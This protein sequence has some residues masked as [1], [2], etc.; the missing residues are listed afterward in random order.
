[1]AADRAGVPLA[2]RIAR[3]KAWAG[4]TAFSAV[5]AVLPSKPIALVYG[6][7]DTEENSLAVVS[8]L[9]THYRGD[10][11]LLCEDPERT[12]TLL[13][14]VDLAP[15]ADLDRIRLVPKSS[16]E[17]LTLF[18]RAELVF[19][20]HG[21]F[22]SPKPMGR[23]YHVNLWHGTGPKR[24]TNQLVRQIV[25]AQAASAASGPW[26]RSMMSEL[27]MSDSAALFTG[28]PR[29]D[30]IART[31]HSRDLLSA[32]GLD[33]ERPVMLWM[34]TYRASDAVSVSRV[35]DGESI[36]SPNSVHAPRVREFIA[37]ATDRGIQLVVKP[38]PLD[39][40]SAD[41]LGIRV[42]RDAEIWG[43][44][45]SLHQLLGSMDAVVSDYS[46]VWVDCLS[47]GISVGL[48]CPDI[49]GYEGTRGFAEP[50]L[51]GVAAGLFI[52][53]PADLAAFA[54]TV[55]ARTVFH[56]D[57]VAAC[58]NALGIARTGATKTAALFDELG[59]A[60]S[61]AGATRAIAGRLK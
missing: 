22:R 28:N 40:E 47:A 46:S 34:P 4:R 48:F 31:G 56:P 39:Q 43:A 7:P 2:A 11:V 35:H 25:R 51:P 18:L 14:I 30:I 20:T 37:A 44:G 19:Y 16:R 9:A 57:A 52:D 50:Q 10:V 13:A 41:A 33:P 49:A 29:Q 3:A 59:T 24:T 55:A 15:E 54:D 23:R 17:A 45:F 5:M 8:H 32:L 58:A 42:L 1:M 21:L 53:T 6:I 38:H 36:F 60:L 26:G 12:R 27:G 61:A